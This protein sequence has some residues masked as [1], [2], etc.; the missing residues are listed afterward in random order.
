M[1]KKKKEET[2]TDIIDRIEEDLISL[3]DK[4]DELEDQ[5]NYDDYSDDEEDE[6]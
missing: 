3:R 2:L 6:Q 4:A 1:V 5:D